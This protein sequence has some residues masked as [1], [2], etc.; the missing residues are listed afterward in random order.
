MTQSRSFSHVAVAVGIL[1]YKVTV[2]MV[3]TE[4]WR[5]WHLPNNLI[6]FWEMSTVQYWVSAP[7]NL[8]LE[9]LHKIVVEEPDKTINTGPVTALSRPHTRRQLNPVFW[10][11]EDGSVGWDSFVVCVVRILSQL[12]CHIPVR[13]QADLSQ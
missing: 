3:T 8:F 7:I 4:I 2:D 6:M 11:W 5:Y 12:C 13:L 9:F 1:N 10:Y